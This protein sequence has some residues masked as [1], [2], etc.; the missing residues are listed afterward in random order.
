MKIR[1]CG[2]EGYARMEC[3]GE[4]AVRAS[5][6]SRCCLLL[7]PV[8]VQALEAGAK[9]CGMH[10]VDVNEQNPGALAFYKKHGFEIASRDEYDDA[11]RPFPILHLALAPEA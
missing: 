8:K 9:D 6:R 7:R 1:T 5:I 3:I 4:G 10:F 2:V 11:G